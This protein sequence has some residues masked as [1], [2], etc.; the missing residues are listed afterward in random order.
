MAL[1]AASIS[2][3]HPPRM[4]VDID[5]EDEVDQLDS[6]LD[7]EDELDEEGR[8]SSSKSRP[9]RTGERTPGHTLIPATRIENILHA[10]GAGAHM[11]KEALFMLSVAAEEFVKRLAQAGQHIAET[12]NHSVVSYRDVAYAAQA[13]QDF[14][15]I[16]DMIPPPIPL[17]YA[18]QLKAAREKAL[19]EED[20]AIAPP[21]PQEAIPIPTTPQTPPEE[22]RFRLRT[23][24]ANSRERLNSTSNASASASRRHRDSRGRWTHSSGRTDEGGS[25]A[26]SSAVSTPPAATASAGGNSRPS[27]ARIRN[28]TSRASEGR[29]LSVPG[30]GAHLLNGASAPMHV[31]MPPP[32]LPS[33]YHVPPSVR[34]EDA[35]PP[36]GHYTGPAS[37]Y[38][39]EPRM[40][41]NAP[42]RGNGMTDAPGRTIYS[43]Q[44]P[45]QMNR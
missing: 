37:G 8:A 3:S 10:D 33:G 41:F 40:M 12:Q 7:G 22:P 2:G 15:F 44:R 5:D 25:S 32:A 17:T 35:W 18:L 28:R 39:D 20:P 34:A 27:S 6:D 23:N 19:A 4:D 16:R 30:N 42:S 31:G 43:H 13:R 1:N 26:V 21:I 29:P 14:Q 9:R 24:H 45:P 36:P 11:S 38:L